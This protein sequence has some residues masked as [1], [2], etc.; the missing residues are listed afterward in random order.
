MSSSQPAQSAASLVSRLSLVGRTLPC[1]LAGHQDAAI[2]VTH[3][4]SFF[5]SLCLSAVVSGELIKRAASLLQVI[6]VLRLW[7]EKEDIHR[8]D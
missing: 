6:F 7:Q 1:F 2:A 5:S 3:P 4:S 8:T